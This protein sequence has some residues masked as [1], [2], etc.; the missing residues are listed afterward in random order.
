MVFS[1]LSFIF[2]F[3]FTSSVKAENIDIYLFYGDGCPHCKAEKEY[4]NEIKDKYE[5]TI[6]E[7]ET[8]YNSDNEKLFFEII[9][10]SFM[11]KRKTLVNGLSNGSIFSS[12]QEVINMLEKL[13]FDTQIRGEKLSIEDFA[14]IADYV[15]KLKK[16][17]ESGD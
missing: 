4:L 3:T 17:K 1:S 6:H 11:Q 13:G 2:L 10:L 14:K 12:K 7:Y 15:E 5:I 8:W 9:K 16:T